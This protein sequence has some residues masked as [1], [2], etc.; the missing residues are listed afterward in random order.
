MRIESIGR[1]SRRRWLALPLTLAAGGASIYAA[2]R[3]WAPREVPPLGARMGTI[4][5]GIHL[6]GDV[7]P[8]AAYAIETSDG[9][10]L[11]DC[12]LEADARALRSR[13]DALEIDWRRL[14]AVFLTH[15]H[16]DHS[17]GAT[18]LRSATGA[19]VYAG[20]GDAAV[21]RSGGPREAFF[22]TFHMPDHAPHP[23]PVDVELKGGESIALGDV[24][25][26][27]MATPGHTPGSICYVLE[28]DGRRSFF[29]GDVIMQFE[30]KAVGSYT[31]Y[32]A[33][34]YRGDARAYLKT[35]RELRAMTVPD[36][37]FPGHPGTDDVPHSPRV[38]AAW[39]AGM[40]DEAI[41]DLGTLVARYDADGADFLDGTPKRILPGVDYLGEFQGRSVY[42]VEHAGRFVLFD[43]PGGSGLA[44]F[45][46][47]RRRGIGARG[48]EPSAV[49]LTAGGPR[50]TAGLADFVGRHHVT[51]IGSTEALEAVRE[52]GLP[53]G[54]LLKA[55]DPK[56][57]DLTSFRPLTL[58]GRGVGPTAY[59]LDRAGKTLVFSGRIPILFDEESVS[60]LGAELAGSASD[61][62]A[63]VE[64][65]KALAAL[66]PDVWLPAVPSDAQ[67]A[68]LYD[69]AWGTIIANNRKIAETRISPRR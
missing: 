51:V 17:G 26:R 32:L 64:S 18:F 66:R 58:G 45:V 13:L 30:G 62:Q 29:A 54:S 47:E 68:N 41:R 69:D 11:I 55:D 27:A 16:G 22:S 28:K 37:L 15:V 21:L 49:L 56:A 48:G 12:G 34:R 20:A 6:I 35:V 44:E 33:P 40:L 24:A 10:I 39:W 7:G 53:G 5:P 31:A 42:T 67:N 4:V 57:G 38:T 1:I 63:Y 36:L 9:P 50:E 65:M 52:L 60:E 19:K 46:V 59:L 8:S 23:T 3:G 61:A 14:K 25:V 43:A 2:R